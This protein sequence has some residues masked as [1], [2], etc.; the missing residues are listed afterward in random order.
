MSLDRRQMDRRHFLLAATSAVMAG[1][2]AAD[3]STRSLLPAPHSP[4]FSDAV[5][6]KDYGAKGDGTGDDSEAINAALER[7]YLAS[8]PVVIPAGQYR[9]LKGIVHKSGVR[10]TGAGSDKTTII[11]MSP[12]RRMASAVGW[13]LGTYG[14]G[15]ADSSV[16][17]EPGIACEDTVAGSR[18]IQLASRGDGAH[19]MPGDYVS[20]EGGRVNRTSESPRSPNAI[21]RIVGVE[22]G[23]G[24][25]HLDTGSP[26]LLTLEGRGPILRR[27]NSGL[28][29]SVGPDGDM[30]GKAHLTVG[31]TLAGITVISTG[32]GYPP[33]NLSCAET[34]VADIHTEGWTSLSGNPVARCTFRG[35][36]GQYTHG[37]VEVAYMSHN[38]N[39]EN[40]VWTR[41]GEDPSPDSSFGVWSNVSEGARDN[42]FINCNLYDLT[43]Q[44]M[45]ASLPAVELHG[46]CK[47]SGGT[48]ISS[49]SRVAVIAYSGALIEKAAIIAHRG[50][51]VELGGSGRIIGCSVQTLSGPP[52]KG[53]HV[54]RW[55][56]G[57]YVAENVLGT[58]GKRTAADTITDEGT[59]TI[60]VNNEPS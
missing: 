50:S 48:V 57:A 49:R 17:R 38:N 60:I 3:G 13:H 59:G 40:C 54:S 20:L 5:N 29:R 11:N 9:T 12:E 1:S 24:L 25:I 15:N 55:G 39:F 6:V 4:A 58:A 42:A 28:V 34:T 23:S 41:S 2:F 18:K 52:S 45:G 56:H 16:H 27:L 51:G 10:V 44:I 7:A 22:P 37:A 36:T 47:W 14:P 30:G 46:G 8:R 26:E 43:D 32:K 53:I 33:I 19:L 35:I 31:A 21:A